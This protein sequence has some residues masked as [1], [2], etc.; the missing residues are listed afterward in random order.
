MNIF[1][2]KVIS[3]VQL[4]EN[5]KTNYIDAMKKVDRKQHWIKGD[6]IQQIDHWDN[7]RDGTL[8]SHLNDWVFNGSNQ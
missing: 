6:H 1:N 8:V 4:K 5:K 3:G 2:Q 7:F